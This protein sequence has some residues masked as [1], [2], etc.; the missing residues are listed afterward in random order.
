M[1]TDACTYSLNSGVAL[2]LS[3]SAS[4]SE[5]VKGGKIPETGF[6]SVML[7]PDSVRRVTPPTTTMPNT[8]AEENMS[9]YPT[10]GRESGGRG[11]DVEDEFDEK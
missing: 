6:H 3:N 10:E 4:Q 1:S 7:R 5:V 2:Y 8:K 9:Q 11:I